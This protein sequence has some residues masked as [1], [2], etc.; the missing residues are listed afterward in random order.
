[1]GKLDNDCRE[2]NFLSTICKFYDWR[3]KMN[4]VFELIFTP[5]IPHNLDFKTDAN[6]LVNKNKTFLVICIF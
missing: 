2:I 4:R 5:C 3:S 1:M 6:L